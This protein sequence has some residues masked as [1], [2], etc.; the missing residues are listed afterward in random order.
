MILNGYL[1]LDPIYKYEHYTYLVENL[2]EIIG[3]KYSNKIKTEFMRSRKRCL[4]DS[5]IV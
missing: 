5:F 3:K 1:M 4:D 2:Y